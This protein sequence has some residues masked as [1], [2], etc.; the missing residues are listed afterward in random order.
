WPI[1]RYFV[2]PDGR[3]GAV[4]TSRGCNYVCTF[5]SQQKFW[6]RTW[7]GREPEPVVEE[8]RRLHDDHGVNVVLLTDE[9]PTHDPDRWEEILD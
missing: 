7:R 3:L 4:A 5:C 8:M 9:Y 2:I 6:D 1:Y